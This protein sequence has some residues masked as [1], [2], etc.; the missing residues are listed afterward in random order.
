[1]N[2]RTGE[3][4]GDAGDLGVSDKSFYTRNMADVKINHSEKSRAEKMKTKKDKSDCLNLR[5]TLLGSSP[6]IVIL[7]SAEDLCIKGFD[8]GVK[9]HKAG[10]KDRDR[11]P[12]DPKVSERL[13]TGPDQSLGDS[14][15]SGSG[16]RV[17][18]S[19]HKSSSCCKLHIYF[20]M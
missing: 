3:G 8:I 19:R 1:M 16:P 4:A 17:V 13:L 7:K 11:V 15:S 12:T 9:K 18:P 20:S 14:S 10:E 5:K 2:S 6:R